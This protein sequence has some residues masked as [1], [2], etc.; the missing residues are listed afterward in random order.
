MAGNKGKEEGSVEGKGNSTHRDMAPPAGAGKLL[1][2][3]ELESSSGAAAV[4]RPRLLLL[5]TTSSC[6]ASKKLRGDSIVAVDKDE[7]DESS[8]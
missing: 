1:P 6:R 8:A 3:A 5:R 4:A 2:S 7:A